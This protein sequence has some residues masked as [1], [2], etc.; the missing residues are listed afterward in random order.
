MTRYQ[1]F[2]NLSQQEEEA[3]LYLPPHHKL[4]GRKK[5]WEDLLR[6]KGLTIASHLL[7]KGT[8][9]LFSQTN[10][11]QT[12]F[13]TN[14]I[15]TNQ[16]ASLTMSGKTAMHRSQP[17]LPAKIL[18]EKIKIEGKLFDWGC[19]HQTDLNYFLK[20]G[21]DAS[22]W[23]PNHYPGK[24]PTSYP[25]QTFSW[26]YCGY[27]LNTLPKEGR[28][29]VLKE[30]FNFLTPKGHLAISVRSAQEINSV[31]KPTWQPFNDGWITPKGTFQK[32]FEEDELKNY[33]KGA[34]FQ[35][36]Q[37]VLTDPVVFL[38]TQKP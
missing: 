38:V 31:R 12:L 34:G 30:I 36:T 18:V 23:D 3:G 6:Q 16:T 37:T 33:L 8:P 27:V 11:Q 13:A 14:E 2:K 1:E 29:K 24:A 15:P 5:Y 7:Q 28:E 21:I 19:G 32:G 25:P 9:Q 17:S 4:I 26:V 22:G 20:S 10:T 35:N